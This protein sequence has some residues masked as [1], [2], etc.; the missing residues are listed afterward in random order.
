MNHNH[1][2]IVAAKRTPLGSFGGALSSLSATQLGAAVVKDILKIANIAPALID[3]VI[4]GNV[5]SANLGQA[6]ARQV[7]L[8]GGLPNSVITSAVNKVCASGMKATMNAAQAI[9]LGNQQAMISGGMESMSQAPYYVPNARFGY[10]YGN[11]V[12]VDGLAKDGLTDVYNGGAM[13]CF[14]DTTAQKYNISREQQDQYAMQSYRRS[15]A[16]WAAG[17]F[18]NEVV[19][20]EIT[21]KKGDI[22]LVS[23]DEEYKAINFDKVPTLKPA[24][25]KDGTITAANASTLNDGAAALMLVSEQFLKDHDLSP[26]AR[27]VGYADGAQAPEWFTTAPI[28]ATEKVLKQ[29]KLQ[30]TDIDYIEVNEAFAVVPLVFQQHF[31]L[32]INRLNVNGGAVSLGH[33]LGCSGARIVVTLLNILQQN[34]AKLGL[35]TICNGGGEASA[36]IIENL[37]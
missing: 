21:G 7:A 4:F 24:F 10:K 5:L 32:D 17:N 13:G 22:T 14:G 29:T 27:I 23:T 37:S 35:A 11:G 30:I 18:D 25:T 36:M 8:Y 15:A 1:V 6:P 12:F 33:P 3:E 26:L 19:G 16:A 2:Y 28:V 31:K 20:V 34:K 9:A